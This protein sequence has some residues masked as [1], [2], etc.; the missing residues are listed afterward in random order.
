MMIKPVIEQ[1]SDKLFLITLPQD[2]EGFESFISTW[3]YKG[4][5]TLVVDPGPSATTDLLCRGLSDIGAASP[6]F[7]LLTHIHIDHSGGVGDMAKRYPDT[8]VVCPEKGIPHLA[9]PEKLWEGS[10]KTLG[11]LAKAYGPISPTPE[12]RLVTPDAFTKAVNNPDIFAV[13]TPGHAPHHESYFA[14]GFLF[15]GEVG[16]VCLPDETPEGEPL[17]L[18]PATPPRFFYETFVKS[19]DRLLARP[20]LQNGGAMICYGH[21]GCADNA[22]MLLENHKKQLALWKELIGEEMNDAEKPGFV[23]KMIDKMLEKD[24]MMAAFRFFSESV[25]NRE[26]YFLTN[27]VKGFAGYLK[28]V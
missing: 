9:A 7:F 11:N 3:V 4:D 6:D 5:V 20:P 2:I 18:R 17:Y 16:G 1:K 24:P 8:S 19:I 13:S 10:V 26:R 28:N 21:H 14:D 12:N 23:D 15:S 22:A 25:Q 27:S